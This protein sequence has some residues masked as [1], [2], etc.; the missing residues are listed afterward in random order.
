MW[1]WN[2]AAAKLAFVLYMFRQV[3]LPVHWVYF[4]HTDLFRRPDFFSNRKVNPCSRSKCVTLTC[5]VGLFVI[6]TERL[7]SVVRRF[8]FTT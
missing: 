7:A 6:T 3:Q 8:L 4:F 1:A 2:F 5:A